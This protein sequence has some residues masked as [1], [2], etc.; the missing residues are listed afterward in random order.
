MRAFVAVKI[1]DR[2]S[3]IRPF[4]GL[5]ADGGMKIYGTG[6]LHITLSFIGEIEDGRL[7]DVTEAVE[8]AARG[9]GPFEIEVGGLGSFQGRWGP[10]TVWAGAGSGGNLE[11]LAER[12]SEELDK[13]GIGHDRKKFVPHIT[14]ARFRD[15]RGAPSAS[16]VIERYEGGDSF[17]FTCKNITIFSSELGPSGAVHTPVSEI[18]L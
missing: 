9:I 8:R 5:S 4:K 3:L 1:P 13:K 6:D 18:F 2:P 17:T 15:G 14:L 16:S 12:I 11:K 7:S 10:R